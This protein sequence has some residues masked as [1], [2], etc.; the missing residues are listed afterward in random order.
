MLQIIAMYRLFV[1][2]RPPR[3]IRAALIAAIGGIDGARWQDDAQLHLTLRFIGEVERP[4]AE[5][6]AVALGSIAAAPIRL[7]LDGV[8]SFD[9]H[10]RVN[11]IWAGVT[12]HNAVVALHRKVD[13]ALIRVGLAPEGR[14]FVPHITLARLNQSMTAVDR[15][16]IGRAGLTSAPALFEHFTLFESVLGRDGA[17][18]ETIERY[19]LIG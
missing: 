2:M 15:Y 1:G 7:A 10:G 16:L 11:A 18:Y 17:K 5:D 19:P 9:R 13:Q 8:G 14:A 4:E 12:P 6:V 3:A